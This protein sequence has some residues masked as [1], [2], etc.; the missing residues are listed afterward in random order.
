MSG[1]LGELQS[2]KRAVDNM[3]DDSDKRRVIDAILGTAEDKGF[4]KW[5]QGHGLIRMDKA[6]EEM[7]LSGNSRCTHFFTLP[8]D[9]VMV[10]KIK[11]QRITE[12]CYFSLLPPL[13]PSVL[14]VV[15]QNLISKISKSLMGFSH[16]NARYQRPGDIM[17]LIVR[18]KDK[19]VVSE[20]KRFGKVLYVSELTNVVGLDTRSKDATKIKKIKGVIDVRGSSKGVIAV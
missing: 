3:R 20:L 10:R 15:F 18:I 8:E 16:C 5:V 12:S 17:R 14:S 13:C 9:L 7:W 4:P 19:S 1:S 11:P 2:Q 6:L